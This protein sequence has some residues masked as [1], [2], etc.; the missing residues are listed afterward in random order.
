[1]AQNSFDSHPTF[2]ESALEQ[3]HELQVEGEP[4]FVGG[5]IT[6]YLQQVVEL[7]ASIQK[8]ASEAD[9][10]ALEKG[11]HKLKSSSAVLGLAKLAAICFAI[12]DS[13]RSKTATLDQAHALEVAVP[14]A[15]TSL[16]S[17]LVKI[18]C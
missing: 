17:Y 9:Q 11:A 13:A 10:L 14:E 6:D 16:N 3:L 15:V 8:A 7:N 12:E 1:M 5:L 18:G 4:S 2:D